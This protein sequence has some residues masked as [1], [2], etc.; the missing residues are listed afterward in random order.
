MFAPGMHCLAFGG[1]DEI[2]LE[3]RSNCEGVG[4]MRRDAY[5]TVE[6][7]TKDYSMVTRPC[8]FLPV[9]LMVCAPMGNCNN[10]FRTQ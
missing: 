3:N 7:V 4:P 10:C 9:R 6:R 1:V 5:S 8:L 2:N